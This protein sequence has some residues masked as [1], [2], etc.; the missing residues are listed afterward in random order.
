MWD[1]IENA[2]ALVANDGLLCISI[3]ND[4]GFWSRVWRFV[5]RNYQRLPVVLRPALVAAVAA[6]R[7]VH[8]AAMTLLAMVLRLARLRNPLVPVINWLRHSSPVKQRGMHWWYDLVDW[9]GGY[10]FEVAKPEAVF[11]FCRRRGFMLTYLSTQGSGHGCNE[12]AFERTAAV[13]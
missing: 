6:T 12:F 4:Q 7:F 1:A 5:K 2:C 8:R 9:V 3:Y 11:N 13:S 10:P